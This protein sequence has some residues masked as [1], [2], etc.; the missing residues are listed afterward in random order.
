MKKNKKEFWSNAGNQFKLE[1]VEKENPNSGTYLEVIG[2]I[3]IYEGIQ[4][5]GDTSLTE[6]WKDKIEEKNHKYDSWEKQQEYTAQLSKNWNTGDET[7]ESKSINEAHQEWNEY[8]EL[9]EEYENEK[10]KWE[11]RKKNN[12]QNNQETNNNIR[13]TTGTS[14]TTETRTNEMT[15]TNNTN[16]ESGNK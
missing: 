2:S 8:L 11:N 16:N 7:L 14:N 13:Q 3:D 15:T 1:Y 5:G 12:K 4:N 6:M 9:K 10:K